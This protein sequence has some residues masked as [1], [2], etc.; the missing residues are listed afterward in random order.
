MGTPTTNYGWTKPTVGGDSNTWGTELNSALDGID[1]T[2]FTML[3]K[4]GGTLTGSL[5]MRAGAVG[6]GSAPAYFQAG[7]ILTTP[8]AHAFEWDG[9]NLYAT[10]STGPTRKTVAFT[11]SS[12]SGNTTGSAAKL[13]TAR[14]IGLGGDL[15]GSS[16]FDGSA[17]ITISATIGTGAVGSS[18]IA[19]GAVGN[20]QMANMAANTVK[21]NNTGSPAAP[22]DGTKAQVLAFLGFSANAGSFT[23][24][25]Q[26]I[27]SGGTLTIAHG[28]GA[29]PNIVGASLV[30]QSSEFGY[31]TN[32]VMQITDP[33][34]GVSNTGLSITS[35]ATNVYV[36]FGSGSPTVFSAVNKSTGGN[37][38]LTSANWKLRLY[39]LIF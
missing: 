8:E 28:L 22:I 21:M 4:T 11:D 38:N 12:L 33:Y 26:T 7:S 20:A 35:D 5:T 27:S 39:A 34:L 18:K 6:A 37:V 15:S 25:D 13:T 31:S 14:S 16:N 29:R 17:N 23:S 30:C 3:P 32:D 1:T 9:T 2:M 19:N 36:T 24:S 10:Q